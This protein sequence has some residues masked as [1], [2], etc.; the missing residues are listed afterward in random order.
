MDINT[1]RLWRDIQELG[2]IGLQKDGGITRLPFTKEDRQAQNWLSVRM[3]EAGL[4]VREDAAGNLIGEHTGIR[5]ELSLVVCGSHYDTVPNGGKFD[6]ALGILSA[7]EALRVIREKGIKLAH[8]IRLAAFKDEE[9]IRFGSGMV[10]SKSISGIM[11][12]SGLDSRDREGITLRQAMTA[13][14]CSPDNLDTCRME[15]L[16]AYLELHIEQGRVLEDHGASIGIVSGIAG[17][18]RY[19]VEINGV[20]GHAGATPM[21]GRKDPVPAM[22]RWIERVT[23]LAGRRKSCVATVGVVHTFPGACNVICSRVSFSLDL[24]SDRQEDLTEIMADMEAFGLELTSQWGVTV[25]LN[26]EQELVPCLCDAS[27]R[28]TIGEICEEEGYPFMELMSGAAHDCM[29]FREVCPVAMIF[30][31]SAGG[32][33]HRKEEFTSREACAQGAQVFFRLLTQMAGG[34]R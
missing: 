20:S 18:V 33:S 6:G 4:S 8:T 12:I 7:L 29:N 9:G 31:P 5:P 10:G 32:L 25:S 16:K 3:K 22:C 2:S 26:R 13:Y 15:N 34:S 21:K 19:T 17:L 27:Y 24:R 14:G 23:D 30:V 11:N 28:K 1:E